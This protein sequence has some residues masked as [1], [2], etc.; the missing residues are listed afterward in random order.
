MAAEF[1][2]RWF[3]GKSKRSALQDLG[4]VVDEATADKIKASIEEEE[5]DFIVLPENW[6]ALCLWIRICRLWHYH[7][8]GGIRSLDWPAIH[9]KIALIESR[10]DERYSM[11]AIEGLELMEIA[12]LPVLNEKPRK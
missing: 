9:A 8:M 10:S 4:G 11:D 2:A 6:G 7:A 3:S 5:S 1:W 12:A